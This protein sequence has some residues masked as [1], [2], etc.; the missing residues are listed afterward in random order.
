MEPVLQLSN[1]ASSSA[2]PQ[3][4]KLDIGGNKYTTSLATLTSEPQSMLAVMFSGRHQLVVDAEGYHFIDRN[5]KYFG[6]ILEWLRTK[7]LPSSL[8]QDALENLN[9]EADF[10]Q[11]TR[12]QN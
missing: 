4:I 7:T 9:R 3:K 8:T 11:L 2:T 5:G 1:T 12:F 10:Y 6:I